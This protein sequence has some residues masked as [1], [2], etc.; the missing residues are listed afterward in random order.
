MRGNLL[1]NPVHTLPFGSIPACAG[2]PSARPGDY[3]PLWV[4]PRVCGGTFL[5]VAACLL[6]AGL[7][8]RVRGNLPTLSCF[9]RSI[10][11]IP[12][13]AGEP[14]DSASGSNRLKVYPRVCGGTSSS[15]ADPCCRTGLSPRVRGNLPGDCRR[16]TRI[17][18]IPACAGEPTSFRPVYWSARVYP[19]V[20]GGTLDIV[21]NLFEESGLSPRVR[22]NPTAW[23]R[24]RP[25]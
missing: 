16:D 5:S 12:A 23:N 22:G 2:E 15:A 18:S 1:S 4:Y 7:S 6:S 9:F 19:R 25:R 14:I 21:R 3:L 20:C 10:G 13:C 17:G 11:S 24:Q 8:P